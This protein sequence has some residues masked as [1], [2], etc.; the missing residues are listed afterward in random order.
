MKSKTISD[1][2][3]AIASTEDFASAAEELTETWSAIDVGSQ[4]VEPILRF[5]EKHPNLDYG[6]P[7]PLVHFMED[8]YRKG[9]EEKLVESVGRKPTMMTVWMLNRCLNGTKA[10]AKR[11]PLIQA[12]R[13]AATNPEVEQ[14]TLELIQGFLERLK[15]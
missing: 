10:P 11:R 7:G 6:M 3:E 9:Y 5:M 2:L 15:G 12:M 4:S 13:E 14:A 8:F 1:Q